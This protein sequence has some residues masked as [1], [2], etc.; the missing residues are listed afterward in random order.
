MIG[1]TNIFILDFASFL[2]AITTLALV[3]FPNMLFHRR[4]ETF[5]KEVLM[6]WKFIIRRPGMLYMIAF[7]FV[8]NVLFGLSTV[9]I[10][11]LVLS[12][13]TP[14]DLA[15]VTTL[16]AIGAM[17]GGLLMSIWGGTKRMASGM[18]GF[19][20][21]EGFFMIISGF[22]PSVFITAVGIFGVWFS[23]TLVNTH[24]QSLIQS[25]VG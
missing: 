3:R 22:R 19:V 15:T 9:L 16:G 24:W 4:E 10:Q 12:F 14:Q 17:A 20:I 25:K 1:M 13:A 5:V 11:P 8:G 7:F 18:V 6:G 2:I 23:V 21:L